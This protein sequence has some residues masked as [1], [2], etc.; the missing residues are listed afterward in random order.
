MIVAELIVSC[1]DED[2]VAGG[3]SEAE[4]HLVIRIKV[5]F[6]GGLRGDGGS[7]RQRVAHPRHRP[8]RA[9]RGGQNFVAAAR[10]RPK[11]QSNWSS[12]SLE[13]RQADRC[14]AAASA[15]AR[16]VQPRYVLARSRE[17]FRKP[18]RSVRPPACHKGRAA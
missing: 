12:C 6:V 7:E 2:R 17:A 9:A 11:Y 13:Q 18:G 4:G 5:Q 3:F 16:L 14:K 1:A 8:Q 10:Y 15:E